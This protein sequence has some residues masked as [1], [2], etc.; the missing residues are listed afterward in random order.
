MKK[1]ITIFLLGALLL[2]GAAFASQGRQQVLAPAS[3]SK[4]GDEN[5]ATDLKL[6]Q[7]KLEFF[8]ERLDFQD[9]RIGD[10]SLYLS[11]FGALMT[12]VVV[13]FSLRSKKEAVLEA[14]EEAKK[15]V[16]RQ[17]KT[18]IEEWLN[19][20]GRQVLTIKVEALLRPEVEKALVEI[21]QAAASTL[22]ELEKEREKAHDH[23]IQ[24]E[25]ILKKSI[26]ISKPL[27]FEQQQQLAATAKELESKPPEQYQ[28]SDWLALGL[29]AYETEKYEIAAGHFAR[30]ADTA[31][32]PVRQ[33]LALLNQGVALSRLDKCED[34][35]SI[36]VDVVRRF[37]GSTEFELKEQVARALTNKGI[38]FD[39]MNRG[40]EAIATYEEVV[41]R[42]EE[43]P[44]NELRELVAI[45]F[46]GIGFDIL[47]AAK[48]IWQEKNDEAG[49]NKLLVQALE[50]IDAALERM[51]DY[52]LYLGNQGYILFL[53][54]RTEEARPILA[55]AVA[56][57][58][59]EMRQT[60]LKDA[61]IFPLPQDEA[62]E[63]L[64]KS[65]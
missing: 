18:I 21:R 17:A 59:E 4:A 45:A 22:K 43:A 36:Y 6:A 23:N 65:L 55:K 26:E 14:K 10:I 35:I 46:N 32:D 50:K 13:F 34:A 49:A 5:T 29:Q 44:E 33:A 12:V 1:T 2:A 60:E 8:K 61:E 63:E 7:Q 42:F 20:D 24:F 19:N 40:E 16:E 31:T 53:L 27:S 56:L 28:F 37:E 48:K 51:P 38:V 64:I 52:P 11:I 47:C 9:K 25:Q 62:F 41:R 15:E 39:Q 57:G 3:V 54:G 30:A 58:G